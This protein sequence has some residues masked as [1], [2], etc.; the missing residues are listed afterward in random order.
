MEDVWLMWLPEQDVSGSS[1][2]NVASY[3]MERDVSK[4]ERVCLQRVCK[5]SN[6]VLM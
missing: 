4:A 1:L 2:G 3:C 6:S 5:A